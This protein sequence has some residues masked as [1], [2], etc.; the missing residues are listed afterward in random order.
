[1][2]YQREM[3]VRKVCIFYVCMSGYM[4]MYYVCLHVTSHQI[5]SLAPSSPSL[6]AY[7]MI[8]HMSQDSDVRRRRRVHRTSKEKERK[9][10]GV[11]CCWMHINSLKSQV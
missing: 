11:N 3:G 2:L 8:H 10:K 1:M 5:S 9:E 7:H 4:Y 6:C